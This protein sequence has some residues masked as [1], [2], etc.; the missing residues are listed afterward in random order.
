MK[1]T[2]HW[3][4]YKD[5]EDSF[6]IERL[7][8]YFGAGMSQREIAESMGVSET[9]ISLWA[10]GK[11]KPSP[12]NFKALVAVFEAKATERSKER[13]LEEYHGAP[14]REEFKPRPRKTKR[15]R[16]EERKAREAALQEGKAQRQA[17]KVLRDKETNDKLVELMELLIPKLSRREIDRV[18]E[19]LSDAYVSWRYLAGITYRDQEYGGESEAAE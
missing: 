2:A 15:Q 8:S 10:K 1:S 5:P 11:R 16:E 7:C 9:T 4:R 17:E 12:D 3:S 6:M 18:V 13:R 19:L 14:L